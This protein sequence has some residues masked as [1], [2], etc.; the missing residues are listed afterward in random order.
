M[1]QRPN[2]AKIEEIELVELTGR[3]GNNEKKI[4]VVPTL[5]GNAALTKD[6]LSSDNQL[7]IT[8]ST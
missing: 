1:I 4:P 5:I 3:G 8:E 6:K 2:E 7:S